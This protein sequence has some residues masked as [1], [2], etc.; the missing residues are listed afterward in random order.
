MGIA[1]Q[2]KMLTKEQWKKIRSIADIF[3]Q[4]ISKNGDGIVYLICPKSTLSPEEIAMIQ[5][6]YSRDPASIL[7][8]LLE[9]AEKGAKKFMQQ[10]YVEYNHKSIGDCGHI[11]LAFEGVSMLAAKAIQD[12]Q[13]YAGQ[14]ASTRY[15]D[16]SDQ[17]FIV[18][19]FDFVQTRDLNIAQQVQNNW[20][21]FYL[22]NLPTVQKFL[23]ETNP[24]ELFDSSEP[25]SKWEKAMKARAFDIMRGFL[26]AGAATCVAW[27]TSISHAGDH[28][29]WLRCHVLKEVRELAKAADVVLKRAY[30]SSFGRNIYSE[31]ENYKRDWY[32]SEY[33]L[34]FE[35]AGL[36]IRTKN[37][38]YRF[39][40]DFHLLDFYKKFIL[41]RPKGVEL[42]WQINEAGTI[43]WSDVID[44]G[45]FRDIQRH[46][47]VT[48]RMGLVSFDFGFHDWYLNNL[49]TEMKGEAL[50][51]LSSQVG[52]VNSIPNM[53]EY[54]KQY[55]IPMGMKVPI[56]ITGSLSKMV[57]LL[58]L[59]AQKTVHPTLHEIAFN[60]S[61]VLRKSLGKQLGISPEKI[62]LFIDG[63][64][65][66]I[67][68][69]RGAQDIIRK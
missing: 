62:P 2:A 61:E 1:K 48:Q 5:S 53:T 41:Q 24:Y 37:P 14:E 43:K 31:R 3:S 60:F 50:E 17:V 18:P 8:H 57:Y 45:S 30:P 33:L 34:T 32:E 11:L 7:F 19:K 68:L 27:W 15:I 65:G 64:V 16:F 36:S 47:A 6:L 23:L 26:P 20:R 28:L 42:P 39:D 12:S 46:R 25:R 52:L 9:V 55:L 29:S 67:T 22:K 58:E 35:T 21:A 40:W 69:K 44:F 13:L 66:Q 54:E 51:F 59:R 56:R 4:K 63:E 49:P 38:E 10:F